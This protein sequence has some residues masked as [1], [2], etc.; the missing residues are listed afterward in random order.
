MI[1]CKFQRSI[2]VY[3]FFEI[4][5]EI[6]LQSGHLILKETKNEIT[7]DHL[8]SNYICNFGKTI[9]TNPFYSYYAAN[10]CLNCLFFPLFKFYVR[11]RSRGRKESY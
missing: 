10:G 4:R 2:S 6:Y 8:W 5:L 1:G 11:A 7:D 3:I 9:I